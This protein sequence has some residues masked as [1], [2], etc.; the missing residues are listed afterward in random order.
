[1]DGRTDISKKERLLESKGE[2]GCHRKSSK[3]GDPDLTHRMG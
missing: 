2:P 3:A 1:M